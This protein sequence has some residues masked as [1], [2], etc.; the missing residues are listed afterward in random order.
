MAKARL[1]EL[2]VDNSKDEAKFRQD[3]LNIAKTTLRWGAMLLGCCEHSA[4]LGPVPD[5]VAREA[6]EPSGKLPGVNFV[7]LS[8]NCSHL[9][10]RKHLSLLQNL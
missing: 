1:E 2:T 6:A 3:L 9:W 7:P 10:A 4:L 8:H 5:A